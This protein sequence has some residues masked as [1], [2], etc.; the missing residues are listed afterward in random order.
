M[1]F[2]KNNPKCLEI[3]CNASLLPFKIWKDY[4]FKNKGL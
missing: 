1:I 4:I 2:K 3:I